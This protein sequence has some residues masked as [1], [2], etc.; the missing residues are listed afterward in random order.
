MISHKHKCIF[1]AVPKTGSTSIRAIIGVAP[2]YHLNIWQIKRN[3]ESNSI[4]F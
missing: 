2:K 1:V 4:G 3:M